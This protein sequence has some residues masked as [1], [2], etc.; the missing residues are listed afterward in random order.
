[1][2][3]GRCASW[4][5]YLGRL[6]AG[7]LTRAAVHGHHGVQA[8][9]RHKTLDVLSG[10]ARDADDARGSYEPRNQHPDRRPP[11]PLPETCPATL[12]E[13]LGEP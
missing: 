5:R 8:V 3:E 10:Y 2:V 9:S 13:L 7:F 6:R 4:R 11:L 1:L 12:D